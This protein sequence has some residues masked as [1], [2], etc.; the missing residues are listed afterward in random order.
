MLEE[1][2]KYY[3]GA[4]G[5]GTKGRIFVSCPQWIFRN[6]LKTGMTMGGKQEQRRSSMRAMTE[7]VVSSGKTLYR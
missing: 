6:V 4:I 5:A 2:G 1:V 7:S 3:T